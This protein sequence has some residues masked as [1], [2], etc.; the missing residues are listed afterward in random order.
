MKRVLSVAL[1]AA[2]ALVSCRTTG[3]PSPELQKRLD[4]LSCPSSLPR[5]VE[6]PEKDSLRLIAVGDA[7]L[8]PDDPKSH[9][10]QTL[11]AMRA[12]GDTD[13][14]LLLG[15]NVYRCGL[16]DAAD[17]NWTRVIAPLLA[18]GKPVYPVLGN[19]D[20][21]RRALFGC[22]FSNPN[23]EIAQTGKPGFEQWIF[24]A[25][26]YVVHTPAVEIILFDSSPIA[27][28]W[29]NDLQR[30]LC[31]LRT[32][33]AQPKRSPWRVVVAH[34]PL[35]SCGE[36]GAQQETV[37]MRQAVESLL[38]ES[39]VDLYVSGHDHDLEI[40]N[41]PGPPVYLVSGSGSRIR[42]N[43]ATCEQGATFKIVGGFAVLDATAEELSVRVFCN[44]QA[45]P[46]MTKSLSH[47]M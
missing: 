17:P 32:A 41:E 47:E 39:Q 45:S 18:L 23:A 19:H 5:T 3:P 4:S 14:I 33:L 20:W 10:N 8:A 21:G 42:T 38:R 34:H 35:F 43:G 31:A 2:A 40:R 26:N 25:A 36:H 15:D 29:P 16:R 46:C 30:S 7:G 24:P 37:R 11:A 1:I 27:E 44:G 22:T 6:G 28:D 12:V 9:L 13:A